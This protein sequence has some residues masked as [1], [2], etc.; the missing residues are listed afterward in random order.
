M[1]FEDTDWCLKV[2]WNIYIAVMTADV[3][4]LALNWRKAVGA[5]LDSS[6]IGARMPLTK[7][8]VRDGEC[9]YPKLCPIISL[10]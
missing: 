1:H 2:S 7:V 9:D 6:Q 3:I 8:L 4:A 10:Y 5:V